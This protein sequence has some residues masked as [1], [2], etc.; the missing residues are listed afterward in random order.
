VVLLTQAESGDVASQYI[1]RPE[2][3]GTYIFTFV[4]MPPGKYY[5]IG[6]TD[7]DGDFQLGD[8]D[9]ELFGVYP[10]TTQP[11]QLDL[12]AGSALQNLVLQVETV[13]GNP[14]RTDRPPSDQT[15]QYR[16]GAF[17]HR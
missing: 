3:D 5:L 9:G 8:A 10:L 14:A 6:G 11:Q 7:N 12:Q 16:P 2:T 1:A 15:G 13:T 4:G 17:A